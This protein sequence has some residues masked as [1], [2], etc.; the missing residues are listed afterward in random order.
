VFYINLSTLFIYFSR[1]W[2]HFRQ[3]NVTR[4]MYLYSFSYGRNGVHETW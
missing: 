4:H 1:F 3:N 2:F